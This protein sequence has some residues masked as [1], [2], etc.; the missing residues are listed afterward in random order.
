MKQIGWCVTRGNSSEGQ[1][2][3]LCRK[4]ARRETFLF[5]LQRPVLDGDNGDLVGGPNEVALASK[6]VVRF[7]GQTAVFRRAITSTLRPKGREMNRSSW[8][9]HHAK[10]PSRPKSPEALLARSL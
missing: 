9:S 2:C 5:R 4:S 6:S 10:I 3:N 1:E 8:R 7:R